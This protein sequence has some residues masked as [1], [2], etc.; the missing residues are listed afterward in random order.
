MRVL[1]WAIAL[2]IVAIGAG[3]IAGLLF[4]RKPADY[5]QRYEAPTS[6]D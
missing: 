6:D 3:F 4:P 5:H 1:R 2:T